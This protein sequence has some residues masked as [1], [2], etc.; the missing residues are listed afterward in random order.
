MFLTLNIHGQIEPAMIVR[1]VPLAD[2]FLKSFQ[3]FKTVVPEIAA[4]GP[5]PQVPLTYI[6][7]SEFYKI[8]VPESITELIT[9]SYSF[10]MLK[11]RSRLLN[12]NRKTTEG[13]RHAISTAI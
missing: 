12:L 10:F 5:S 1:L 13:V 4:A 9:F 8:S 6:H 11:L 7:L 2:N 3:Q